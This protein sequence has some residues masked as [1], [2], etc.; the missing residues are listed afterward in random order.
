GAWFVFASYIAL[1]TY[2]LAGVDT[3]TNHQIWASYALING[4]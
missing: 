3:I 4:L 1:L 2:K